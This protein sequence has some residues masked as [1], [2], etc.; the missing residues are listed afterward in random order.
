MA[1]A[2]TVLGRRYVYPKNA[3]FF[4]T[5]RTFLPTPSSLNNLSRGR[6]FS[7]LPRGGRSPISP[8]RW[9]C[10]SAILSAFH[11]AHPRPR[12]SLSFCSSSSVQSSNPSSAFSPSSFCLRHRAKY[13]G[14]SAAL[15]VASSTSSPRRSTVLR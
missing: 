10:T 12:C 4:R 6:F 13:V 8:P 7:R 9:T 11:F 3:P 14:P 5:S 1:T 15:A 2:S